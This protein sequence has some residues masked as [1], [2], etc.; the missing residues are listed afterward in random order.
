MRDLALFLV[1]FGSL[2]LILYRPW[3]G[4]I[5]WMWV[6]LM[7]PH[8][9]AWGLMHD[10]PV[11]MIIG[12]AT[13]IGWVLTKDDKRLPINAISVL[14]IILISWAG[15]TTVFA[16]EPD[17]AF[18]KFDLF[19]KIILMTLI[20]LSL[21]KTPKQ[22]DYYV[23]III[24]SIGYFCVKGGAFTILTGGQFRVWGPPGTN[25]EDNNQLALATLMLIPIMVY[26]AQTTTNVW[27]KRA[28]YLSA[29]LSFASVVG[30]YSRG[31]FVGMIAVSIAMWWRSKNK[32]II[33]TTAVLTVIVGLAFV[34]QQWLD[35]MDTIQNYE[36]EGSA[37]GRLELWGHAIRIANDNPILGG[38]FGAF[39]HGPS[40]DRL[41]PEIVTRRNVHS[42]YFEMLGT[43]G[44]IGLIIFI[45]LGATGLLAAG[46]IRRQCKGVPGLK[47]EYLFGNAI[48]LSLIAYAVSGTFLNLSTY[49][50]YY[51]LL[52][53]IVVQRNLL[54]QKLASGIVP[55]GQQSEAA[56]TRDPIPDREP[57]TYPNYIPGR[58]YLRRAAK[59]P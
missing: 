1:I 44:Y 7:N 33:G 3:I 4:V 39:E 9:L 49:D 51:A 5:M 47:N 17:E 25:I 43:Q 42:I 26:K 32:I 53:M 12:L 29:I 18:R 11:A 38:G 14:M 45:I 56:P 16:L 52:A 37:M 50:L 57:V 27:I 15:L 30:S 2:P 23:W 36:T 40:Y 59:Q 20:A 19:F 24:L 10:V 22:F 6:S 55:D 31:A 13:L 41:S 21:I 35:R 34:P 48:Q 54:N 28:M 8:K 46:K 58:S